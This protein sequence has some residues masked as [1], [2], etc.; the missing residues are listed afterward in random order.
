[1]EQ[2]KR[3]GAKVEYCDPYFSEFPKMRRHNFNLKTRSFTAAT[4][5][6][7]DCVVIATDHDLF[8]YDLI[9]SNASLVVDTRGRAKQQSKRV[10]RA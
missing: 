9:F 5:Q 2:L 1:M 3:Q 7:F 10:F 4:L 6:E 8:D